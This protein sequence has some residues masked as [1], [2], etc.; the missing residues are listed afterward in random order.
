MDEV[1]KRNEPDSHDPEDMFSDT[2]MTFGEHIEDLRSH[3]L[4]AIY[5]FLIGFI[6]A[7]PLGP[8]ALDFIA[9]PVTDQLTKFNQ[10]YDDAKLKELKGQ[11]KEE[12]WSRLPPIPLKFDANI[13]PLWE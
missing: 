4:R 1:M 10:R 13:E 9:A 6:I 12:D 2:R 11:M 8:P 7:I 3:L 5:G